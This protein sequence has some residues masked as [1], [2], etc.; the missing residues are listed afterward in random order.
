MTVYRTY[1]APSGHGTALIEP[2][3]SAAADTLRRNRSKADQWSFE[4]SGRSLQ[5][6]RSLARVELLQEAWAYS[7][8]YRDVSQPQSDDAIVMAGH[9]PTLFHPGVWFKNFALD[10]V[11]RLSSDQY[12]PTTAINLVI[13]NDVANAAA[14]R[15]PVIDD[16]TGLIRQESVPFDVASGGVPFEQNRIRDRATFE[17]FDQ[18]LEAS[19]QPIVATP[20]VT[21]LWKH[22]KAAVARCE[23][24]SCAIAHARHGLEGELG[25]N[26]LE[27]PLS[28]VC[29]SESFAAFALSVLC[30]AMRFRDVYNR[31]VKEYRIHHGI[32][33]KA[34]PVP[35]L[36]TKDDWI[37]TPFWIYGD[38]APQR[39][40]LYVRE[41][42][43]LLELS[44]LKAKTKRLSISSSKPEAAPELASFQGPLWKL[45]PRA[46]MTTMYARTVLSDLFIHGIGGAKYDQL[47][48][49]IL[50]RFFGISALEM[51]V[52]SAT[53][54]LPVDSLLEE[55]LSVES[56]RRQLRNSRFAPERFQQD[57]ALPEPLLARKRELLA[58]IPEPGSRLAWH[59]EIREVNLSLAQSLTEVR[60][61][62]ERQ[63]QMA[64]QATA[65]AAILKSREYSFCLFELDELTATFANMLGR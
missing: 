24:V 40:P 8:R 48:D 4:L 47:G 42:A 1:R 5:S 15:V 2:A 63:L 56:I 53:V 39:R 9:Q 20:C 45:R 13:D 3:L 62:L 59:R 58:S 26:T 65:S 22:A 25:L 55:T 29:R 60:A 51:M 36:A 14:V 10:G 28:V 33:S 37:E 31:S 30:D 7:R 21:R 61:G 54:H 50:E 43:G 23:N 49:Q 41:T 27:L 64:K 38:D 17:S 34:H 12:R 57:A 44:D 6:L 19:V 18:R 46:L 32:R 11:A 16:S 52:V 35:E